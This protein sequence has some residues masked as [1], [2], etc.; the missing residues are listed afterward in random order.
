MTTL[1]VVFIIQ[2]LIVFTLLSFS[3][4]AVGE[5]LWGNP[6][7]VKW[8]NRMKGTV[9]AFFSIRLLLEQK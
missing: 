5:R 4:G 9:F 6:T 2:A 8:I 7:I 3:A 1:G